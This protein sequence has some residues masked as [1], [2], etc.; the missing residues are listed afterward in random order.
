MVGIPCPTNDNCV[1]RTRGSVGEGC[2]TN[3]VAYLD[4]VF[5][6][7]PYLKIEEYD[8]YS[9]CT[10]PAGEEAAKIMGYLADGACHE[11]GSRYFKLVESEDTIAFLQNEEGCDDKDWDT[12]WT[13]KDTVFATGHCFPGVPDDKVYFV[14]NSSIIGGNSG[15]TNSNN[16]PTPIHTT[17]PTAYANKVSVIVGN[18]DPSCKKPS[19][20]TIL[21]RDC[22]DTDMF[23]CTASNVSVVGAT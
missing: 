23:G 8:S 22:S 9:S 13:G 3:R 4:T 14:R 21:Q 18:D 1:I 5:N 6:G 12:K 19:I 7:V 16:L 10:S 2:A 11:G 20:A 15:T 17:I